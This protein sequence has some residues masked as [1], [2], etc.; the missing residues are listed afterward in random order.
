MA[1]NR[2]RRILELISPPPTTQNDNVTIGQRGLSTQLSAEVDSDVL[3]KSNTTI[4]TDENDSPNKNIT[5]QQ[6]R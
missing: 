4:I 2:A 5:Q 6:N 1:S 3:H